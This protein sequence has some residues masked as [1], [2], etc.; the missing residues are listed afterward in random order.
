MV[1]L[2]TPRVLR[3]ISLPAR[4][5]TRFD[6]AP[7]LA[8]SGFPGGL[9]PID[10]LPQ[11]PSAVLQGTSDAASPPQPAETVAPTGTPVR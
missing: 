8:G 9:L 1:L 5:D 6:A 2:I 3:N 10:E 7:E 11:D 4:A